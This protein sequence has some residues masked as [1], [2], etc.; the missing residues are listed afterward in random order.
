M[1]LKNCRIVKDG[2]IIDGDILIENGRIKKIAKD[3]KGGDEVID[4]KNS[5]VIPGVIDAHVHFRWGEEKKEDFL[6][7][8]LAAINGGVCFAIDMPNNKPPIT[9][10]ELFYKKLEDCKKNSKINIFLNFGV[11]ERNYFENIEDAKAYKIFMVKSVGDLYIEDYSKLKDILNQNKLF[12]IHAEHKDVIDEN[13]KKYSLKSWIDHCKIRDEKSE[14]EAVKEVIK[15]L[16]IIDKL[17][18]K[19]PHVHFCHISTKEALHLIKKAKQDLKNVKI[20]VEAT[21]HHIYLNKDMA[22]ELKGFGKFNPPLR[23]KEDNIALIKGIVNE[24]V[25]IV[26]SDHAPHLLEDKIKDVK[27][28]PSGIPGVETIVPLTLN[29]VNKKLITLFDAVRVLSE[30][31]AKIFKINNK[32]EEGNLANLTIVDLK[33][34]GKINAELFKSKAKFSPFDK[35]EIKGFPIYTV[36]NGKVYEAYGKVYE[37]WPYVHLHCN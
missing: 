9:T 6:S 17:G 21:P 11:T 20:S 8:S 13:L 33:K 36:V 19:K 24:D 32:I 16:K 37:R 2:K 31:P 1:L 26:A 23:E 5:I 18:D 22:E 29:L 15:Y 12:C 14:V 28:C 34:E 27:N 30:N 35:W 25:D 3:I 10:K 4:I 7:G